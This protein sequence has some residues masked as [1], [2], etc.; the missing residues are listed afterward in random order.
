[1]G[2]QKEDDLDDVTGKVGELDLSTIQEGYAEGIKKVDTKVTGKKKTSGKKATALKRS[3][4]TKPVSG[5]PELAEKKELLDF[6]DIPKLIRT[7]RA[8]SAAARKHAESIMES[9]E[10]IEDLRL[11]PVVPSKL[12]LPSK[13]PRNRK[14]K[15]APIPSVVANDTS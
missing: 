4:K 2:G 14:V 7:T 13:V 15:P 5:L 3:T 6:K 10:D 11:V 12:E 1:M 9:S 8:Q